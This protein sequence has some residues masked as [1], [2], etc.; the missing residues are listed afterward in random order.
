MQA[1]PLTWRGAWGILSSISA[2]NVGDTAKD[3]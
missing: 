1:L 2:K 3:G